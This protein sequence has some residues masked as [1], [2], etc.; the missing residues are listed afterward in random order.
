MAT[1]NTEREIK[2]SIARIRHGKQKR[3]EPN[4][5]LS[6]AAVADEAGISNATIHNRYP[7][8]A[9]EIRK[10]QKEGIKADVEKK[11]TELGEMRRKIS[12][13][14]KQFNESEKALRKIAIINLRM[15]QEINIL[16]AALHEQNANNKV[17]VIGKGSVRKKT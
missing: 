12:E 4:R 7:K 5:K 16:K 1:K 10:L 8:L 9:D 15:A 3:I 14:R 11:Q 6:I 17:T 13:V 2:L